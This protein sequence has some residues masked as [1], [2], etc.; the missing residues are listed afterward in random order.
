MCCANQ[1]Q[2]PGVPPLHVQTWQSGVPGQGSLLQRIASQV[3]VDG[4]AQEGRPQCEYHKIA[5]HCERMRGESGEQ[6]T[7]LSGGVCQSILTIHHQ[8]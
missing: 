7:N 4:S 6:L 8:E 2:T 3:L 5:C 1:G